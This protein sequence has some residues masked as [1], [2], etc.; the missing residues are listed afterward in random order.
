MRRRSCASHAVLRPAQPHP[1][2]Q[3][4]TPDRE[5]ERRL[6]WLVAAGSCH[7]GCAACPHGAQH[8]A[9][10]WAAARYSVRAKHW[11]QTAKCEALE[12]LPHHKNVL[13]WPC[14][15][16]S[17]VSNALTPLMGVP[18]FSAPGKT[19]VCTLVLDFDL[20]PCLPDR[21]NEVLS[22]PCGDRN[23]HGNS[24]GHRYRG[25]MARCNYSHDKHVPATLAIGC[26]C[27]R[28]RCRVS[29]RGEFTNAD[30]MEE[31]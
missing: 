4:R 25:A 9:R 24:Y 29:G 8:L 10:W 16:D 2:R 6:A 15:G 21:P 22:G 26:V 14:V 11:E 1:P 31:I 20:E 12:G 7:E 3:T 17:T 13:C 30:G 5:A 19:K 28:H 23:L 18:A 27:K